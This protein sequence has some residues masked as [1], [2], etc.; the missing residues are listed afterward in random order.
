MELLELPSREVLVQRGPSVGFV[1]PSMARV[2]IPKASQAQGYV[3]LHRGAHGAWQ[4]FR[5]TS[6]KE[7][8][9]RKRAARVAR[10]IGRKI[11]LGELVQVAGETQVIRSIATY[12][13][14]SKAELFARAAAAAGEVADIYK[15]KDPDPYNPRQF[16]K[17]TDALARDL[18][19]VAKPAFVATVEKAVTSSKIDWATATEKQME[20]FSKKLAATLGVSAAAVWKSIRPTVVD[21]SVTMAT[22]SRAAFVKSNNLTVDRVISLQDKA[23]VTRS[24]MTNAHYVREFATGQMSPS[25]SSQ[26]RV[27]VQSGISKGESSRMIGKEL[28]RVLGRAAGG[29]TE[30]YFRM[31]ASAIN[32]RSREFSS[33]RSMQDAGIDKYEW[34]S[35]LDEMTTE[36]CRFLDGQVFSV[37]GALD[38]YKAADAL[39]DPTDIKY[40]MPWFYD[41]PIRGGEHDGKMGI[42]MNQRGGMQRVAV[43]EKGGFGKRD[44]IGT[45][46]NTKSSKAL[47]GM[48]MPACPGHSL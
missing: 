32:A 42:F 30:A 31:A 5:L 47:E 38:R 36:T 22:E 10:L 43:V 25:L 9:A 33:L 15:A 20:A 11:I 40:E 1:G 46:S 3:L 19:R 17:M 23:A 18:N 8:A 39:E 14:M 41:K 12:E 34:S 35:V 16:D 13:T 44:A 28:H 45:Y 6:R 4:T 2:R 21:S 37:Q 29:Q 24:A 27:I 7:T 26:A 48:G